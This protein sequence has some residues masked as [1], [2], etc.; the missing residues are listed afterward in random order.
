MRIDRI[1]GDELRAATTT[2]GVTGLYNSAHVARRL[3]PPYDRELDVA[4]VNAFNFYGVTVT[5]DQAARIAGHF[6]KDAEDLERC[7]DC[8]GLGE[9][10]RHDSPDTVECGSCLG[11]G[12]LWRNGRPL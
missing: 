10:E 11:R 6:Q 9:H 5:T 7:E 12:A 2:E 8:D 3:P 4:I 1:T